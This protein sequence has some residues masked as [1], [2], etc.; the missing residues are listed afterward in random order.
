MGDGDVGPVGHGEGVDDSGEADKV[1]EVA[2]LCK[3]VG[4]GGVWGAR[5]GVKWGLIWG[6]FAGA[7]LILVGEESGVGGGVGEEERRLEGA[8]VVVVVV[9]VSSSLLG[10]DEAGGEDGVD[11]RVNLLGGPVGLVEDDGGQVRVENEGWCCEC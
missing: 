6:E 9:V 11:A 10:V 7:A 2:A 5:D 8:V 3:L 4:V 1:A